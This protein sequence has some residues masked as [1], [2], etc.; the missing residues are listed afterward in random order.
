MAK[1]ERRRNFLVGFL[2]ARGYPDDFM[3]DTLIDPL[4][5]S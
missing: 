1:P 4:E 3:A 2:L 5:M